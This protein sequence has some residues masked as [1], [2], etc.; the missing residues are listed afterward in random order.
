MEKYMHSSVASADVLQFFDAW[1]HEQ[2][3]FYS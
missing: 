2:N 1:V 3:G